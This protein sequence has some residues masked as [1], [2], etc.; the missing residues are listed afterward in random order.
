MALSRRLR[1]VPTNAE[2]DDRDPL[3][4]VLTR[5][6]RG[7]QTAFSQLYDQLAPYVYGVVLRV[8]RDRS[9]SETSP[10]RSQ[11]N[12]SMRPTYAESSAGCPEIQ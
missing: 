6:G 12:Y 9:Q 11:C 10:G 3:A 5:C 7:D 1:S 4:A 8:V 2:D